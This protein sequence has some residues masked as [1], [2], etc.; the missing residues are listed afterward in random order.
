MSTQS[1]QYVILGVKFGYNQLGENHPK[2]ADN[3]SRFDLIEP[4]LDD[5]SGGEIF[6]HNGLCLISDGM[7]GKYELVGRVLLKSEEGESLDGPLDLDRLMT[8]NE[9]LRDTI[10][11]LISINFEEQVS[12]TEVGLWF[13]THYR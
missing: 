9:H 12:P 1:N 2:L 5:Q 3:A 11:A 4:Y 10:A 6:H 7:C 8:N 13:V